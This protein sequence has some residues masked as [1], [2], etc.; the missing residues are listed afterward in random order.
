MTRTLG[1]AG[2]TLLVLIASCAGPSL[3]PL[4]KTGRPQRIEVPPELPRF[5][6][7]AIVPPEE[8]VRPWHP[9]YVTTGISTGIM[10]DYNGMK[11]G[12]LVQARYAILDT[13]KCGYASPPR[14]ELDASAFTR[15]L[16]RIND[17]GQAFFAVPPGRYIVRHAADWGD[18]TYLRDVIVR[19][20]SYSIIT[21]TV[22]PYAIP[23]EPK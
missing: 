3:A 12:R 7:H 14:A 21:V 16:K 8:I 13:W 4:P 19:E 15:T 10:V 18:Q 5:T 22:L 11:K 23:D 2:A 1:L 6:P 20:G 17:V 9:R